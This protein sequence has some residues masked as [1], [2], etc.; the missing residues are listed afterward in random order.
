V[1][2]AVTFAAVKLAL[3]F[4]LTLRID[5]PGYAYFRDEFTA[6]PAGAISPGVTFDLEPIEHGC[7]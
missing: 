1:H 6:S 5:H 4:A 3:H 7:M 2:G